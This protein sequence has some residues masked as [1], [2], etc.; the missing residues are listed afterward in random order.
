M[1]KAL[2]LLQ[3]AMGSIIGGDVRIPNAAWRG[4]K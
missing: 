2:L 3:G 4:Q 1:V